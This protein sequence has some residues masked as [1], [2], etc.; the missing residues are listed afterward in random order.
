MPGSA[1]IPALMTAIGGGGAAA[2][3]AGGGFL[4]TI[5]GGVISGIGAGMARKAESKDEERKAI[6]EETRKEERY[7]GVGQATRLWENEAPTAGGGID[8]EYQRVQPQDYGNA[9]VGSG[10]DRQMSAGER[11]R[12]RSASDRTR[13]TYDP[14]K[15]RIQYS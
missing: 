15:R 7:S 14:A 6:A 10:F 4:S 13:P 11:F 9:R 2:G 3:V 5:I 12:D 8:P 1:A